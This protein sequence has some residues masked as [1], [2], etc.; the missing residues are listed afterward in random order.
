LWCFIVESTTVNF[1]DIVART[2]PPVAVARRQAAPEA[3]PRERAWIVTGRRAGRLLALLLIAAVGVGLGFLRTWPPLATVMSG[4]MSPTIE[5]GDVVVLQKLDG[6]P[7]VGD[8]IAVSVPADAR[9]RYGYPPEVI[10]R[11]VRISADGQ[12]TTKGDARPRVDPFTTKRSAVKAKVVATVPAAGRV[13]AF[14]TST[15]GLIWIAS[16]VLMLLVLPLID[17]QRDHAEREEESIQDLRADL[18]TVLAEVLRSQ[19]ETRAEAVAREALERRIDELTAATA[20]LREEM[21]AATA[22]LVELPERIGREVAAALPVREG[23]AEPAEAVEPEP[24]TA[25]IA[26]PAGRP[27]SG[28]TTSRPRL[29]AVATDVRALARAARGP[30]GA[31]RPGRG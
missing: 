21:A 7:R 12:I 24:I 23:A 19:D 14:L 13:L 28:E 3:R 10:H 31:G 4:S 8:V 17:R 30:R 18:D 2:A 27:V 11:V 9:S 6:P 20:A 5:T 15:L 22:A 26:V 1:A 16:G 25:S 29:R